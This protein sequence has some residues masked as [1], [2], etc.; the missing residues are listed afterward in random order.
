MVYGMLKLFSIFTILAIVL[1]SIAPKEYRHVALLAVSLGCVGYYSKLGVVFLLVTMATTYGAGIIMNLI[2]EKHSTKGLEKPERKKVKAH[3]KKCKKRVVFA[4]IF[5]NIGVLFLLKYFKMFF[6]TVELPVFMNLALPLGISYYTLQSLSYVIDVFRGKFKAEKDIFKV[7]LFVAFLP[8]LHEGPFGRYDQYKSTMFENEPIKKEDVFNGVGTMLWGL[9]K[10]FMVANRAAIIAD[11][12]F[13]NYK[14]YNGI[15]IFF[16]G[17]AF[18]VQL[19]AEFSGYID[20]ARG[21]SEIFGIKLA[22]NFDMPFIARDVAEFW[23][24]WH[25]SLGQWFRDYIFYPVSTAKIFKKAPDFV[26]INGALLAVWFLTGLWHGAS[27]KY[28]VYGLYYFVLMVLLNVLRPAFEKLWSKVDIKYGI[29]ENSRSIILIQILLTQF[30]V[31]IGMI[32]FRATN[33]MTFAEMMTSAINGGKFVSLLEIMDI[34]EW[35]VFIS[36]IVILLLGPALEVKKYSIRNKYNQ[37]SSAQKYLV[38]LGAACCVI[39][40]GAYGLDYIPPDPIYGGF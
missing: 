25:I 15:S 20:V 24:R 17:V 14:E 26:T 10:I 37:L 33:L 1:Y 18:T 3:G 13:A 2:D 30:L 7:G 11:N 29:N 12:V 36:S 28:V 6:P 9:F 22:K 8:Q 27:W 31:V 39:I 19:Y 5:I 23:R 40:F 16:G 21:V 4:Y 34:K 32:M 35:I 38:C